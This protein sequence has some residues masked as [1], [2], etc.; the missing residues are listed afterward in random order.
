MILIRINNISYADLAHL[1][2]HIPYKD[3]VAGSSPAIGIKYALMAEMVDAADLSSA[4][5]WM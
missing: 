5:H 4:T 1:G 3:R 2:E